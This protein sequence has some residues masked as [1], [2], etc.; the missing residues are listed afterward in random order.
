VKP[1]LTYLQKEIDHALF[2]PLAI[3]RAD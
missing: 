1:V 2:H 3:G